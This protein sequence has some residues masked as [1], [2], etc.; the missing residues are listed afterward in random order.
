VIQD[1]ESLPALGRKISHREPDSIGSREGYTEM[2]GVLVLIL[3]ILPCVSAL[4]C[5]LVRTATIRSFIVLATGFVLAACSILLFQWTPFVWTPAAALKTAIHHIFQAADFA[6]LGVILYYGLKHGSTTVS[7][8]AVVQILLVASIASP[9]LS[10]DGEVPLVYCDHL[11]LIMV[12]IV[13]VVGPLIA[14][15]AIPYMKTH[16]T[17]LNLIT[18]RQPG[19]FA[20]LVVFLGAMN[21]MVLSNDLAHFYFF[22][23]AT[24]LCSFLLIRHDRSETAKRNAVKALWMNSLGGCALALAMVCVA[25]HQG[26]FDIHRIAHAQNGGGVAMLPL[27]LLCL[28]AFTKS[29][30]APF[31]GWLLGAMVAPTPVS[32]LLH[33][34][35]MVKAGVYLVLRLAPSFAGTF[36]SLCIA[37]FGAFTFT[38]AAALAMGQRNSKKILAYST[39]SNLGLIFACAGINSPGAITAAILLTVFHAVSKALLFLCVGT[40]E[41]HISSRDIEDMRGLNAEMPVTA[42]ITVL[43]AITMI[44]PPFG[45]VLGKWMA[46]EFAGRSLP[47]AFMLTLGSALTV[48]YWARWAGI[49]MSAPFAGRIWLE[50]QA[51]LT[52]GPLVILCAGMMAVGLW[53]TWI[54]THLVLPLLVM[55]MRSSMSP[56]EVNDGSFVNQAGIFAVY[57]LFFVAA[58][59]VVMGLAAL[60]RARRFRMTAP[61][62]SGVQAESGRGVFRG[63]MGKDVEAAVGSYYLPSMFGEDRLTVCANLGAGALLVLML[64]GAL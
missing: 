31:Q 50:R 32:A 27:A 62:L 59:G 29:A 51:P 25:L 34:S 35:T 16:E 39:V 61:Y 7:A 18:S 5:H 22:F 54:Y 15:Y 33:S 37:L 3:V 21:G 8:L 60:S 28:A 53:A 58:V 38:A 52:R 10:L 41:Q 63:P 24:T 19:F 42:L 43:G 17:H 57:P 55:T 49:L 36:L 64:G 47:I 12:L 44:L 1:K 2:P 30:Q 45:M 4:L 48:V 14:A 9:R 11:S 26:S 13:S 23:E 6:V 40:I 56:F 46:M 20:V